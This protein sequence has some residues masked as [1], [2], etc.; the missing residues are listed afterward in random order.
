MPRSFPGYA[1]IVGVVKSHDTQ[2]RALVARPSLNSAAQKLLLGWIYRVPA[3]VPFKPS[4]GLLWVGQKGFCVTVFQ[5]AA[6]Q[7]SCPQKKDKSLA[8]FH[9]ILLSMGNV[10]LFWVGC[11]LRCQWWGNLQIPK[12]QPWTNG[13][14]VRWGKHRTQWGIFQQAV[15]DYRQVSSISTSNLAITTENL[16]HYDQWKPHGGPGEASMGNF[17]VPNFNGRPWETLTHR[18]YEKC[19]TKIR[20][21]RSFTV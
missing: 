3:S 15:F 12:A 8:C 13:A 9:F 6:S 4:L 1:L 19:W 14:L 7:W 5:P 11:T 10:L 18:S 17:N 2:K 21:S 20:G 16:I